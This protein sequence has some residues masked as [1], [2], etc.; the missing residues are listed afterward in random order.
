MLMVEKDIGYLP[1]NTEGMEDAEKRIL[2]KAVESY[3]ER[4]LG[5]INEHRNELL[6]AFEQ[7]KYNRADDLKNQLVGQLFEVDRMILL[8]EQP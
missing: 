2:A 3:K 4:L 6:E 1:A 8:I 5:R 7:A